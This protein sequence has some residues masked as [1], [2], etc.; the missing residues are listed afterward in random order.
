[1]EAETETTTFEL[2]DQFQL[3]L[4]SCAI[5]DPVSF[6]R[7]KR[8][9][10]P[11]SP[12]HDPHVK[13]IWEFTE[14]TIEE[15]GEVP[16]LGLVAQAAGST[17]DGEEYGDLMMLHSDLMGHEPSSPRA[18]IKQAVKLGEQYRF[19]I[20]MGKVSKL[21]AA[22]R[23][24]EAQAIMD[25]RPWIIDSTRTNG[26]RE[27][28][29]NNGYDDLDKFIKDAQRRR[30]DPN[31][32]RL[33]TGIA[34][35]D[36]RM[37]GGP[38]V[39]DFILVIG[40]TGRGKT[41]FAIN[42][43]DAA[44]RQGK[45]GLYLASEMRDQLITAKIFAR[46]LHMKQNDIYVYR[47]DARQEREFLAAMEARKKLFHRLLRVEQLGTETMSREG[48]VRAIEEAGDYLIDFSWLCVDT[49][50]H[51][52]LLPEYKY[53][54][55]RGFGA[56]ANWLSGVIDTYNLA[57]IITTQSNREGSDRTELQHAANHSESIRV[58]Q[59]VVSINR[60]DVTD[61][62]P[63]LDPTDDFEEMIKPRTTFGTLVISLLKCRFGEPGDVPV[64]TDLAMSYMG[65]QIIDAYEELGLYDLRDRDGTL[66]SVALHYSSQEM[67]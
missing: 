53:N 2:N 38:A 59:N 17:F 16:S 60:T 36:E 55:V 42:L 40:W 34:A 29:V 5:K 62:R 39:G 47:F 9:L 52:Q 20:H 67:S 26:M 48:I 15:T 7:A 64:T 27:R 49:L 57:G 13:W 66:Q 58:A 56:N 3:E 19:G 4:L 11:D 63:Q 61:E 14:H 24:V 32:F 37:D 6:V 45:G 51:C 28:R 1:M 46:S 35:L 8:A 25:A 22:G 31:G 10:G 30:D 23:L 65:D 18:L 33:S 21:I 12:F 41:T 44:L 43:V 54:P 50:D